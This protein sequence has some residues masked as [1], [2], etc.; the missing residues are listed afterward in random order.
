GGKSGPRACTPAWT[1]P[2]PP[3]TASSSHPPRTASAACRFRSSPSA[4]SIRQTPA[5]PESASR[6]AAIESADPAFGLYRT[7]TVGGGPGGGIPPILAK[8]TDD[9][10]WAFAAC[11]R[12]LDE[13][14]QVDLRRAIEPH[15]D[16]RHP[17]PA[18]DEHLCRRCLHQP[19]QV[20]L[21][22]L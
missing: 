4:T 21:P 11:V 19:V 8:P 13:R 22:V 9:R 5:R 1:V 20:L 12:P 15:R 17:Q 7:Q 2:P 10:P 6:T 3:A 14:N 18:G 16:G